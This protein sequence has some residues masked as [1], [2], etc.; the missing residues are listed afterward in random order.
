MKRFSKLLAVALAFCMVFS[1]NFIPASA[2]SATSIKLRI[3]GYTSN[4]TVVK[5]DKL[6]IFKL[7]QPLGSSTGGTICTSSNTNVVQIVPSQTSDAQYIKAVGAGTAVVTATAKNGSGAKGSITVRVASSASKA[8]SIDVVSLNANT[9]KGDTVIHKDQQLLLKVSTTPTAASK[10]MTYTSSNTNVATVSNTGRVTGHN[11]GT[12]TITVRTK[13]GSNKTA[14]VKVTVVASQGIKD[15]VMTAGEEAEVSDFIR[16]IPS[17]KAN[18]TTYTSDN[19]NVLKVVDGK[20]VA[21]SAGKAKV[22]VRHEA[23][24]LEKTYTFTVQPSEVDVE[25]ITASN[26]DDLHKDSSVKIDAKV[27]P[28]SA[29]QSLT[30]EVANSNIASVDSNGNVTGKSRGTTTIT[31]SSAKNPSI[32]KT[33]NVTVKEYLTRVTRWN[34]NDETMELVF[35]NFQWIPNNMEDFNEKLQNLVGEI[36]T[37]LGSNASSAKYEMVRNGVTYT[38]EVTSSGMV[39]KDADGN[40]VDIEAFLKN[41]QA[42]SAEIKIIVPESWIR[43]LLKYM[44]QGNTDQVLEYNGVAM[45]AA[46]FVGFNFEFGKTNKVTIVYTPTNQTETYTYF[47]SNGYL[48]LKSDTDGDVREDAIIKYRLANPG[49]PTYVFSQLDPGWY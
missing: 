13:D 28:A 47:V 16:I 26:I 43:T 6:A 19:E 49:G 10:M 33:I 41:G 24:E 27:L 42:S 4:I 40:Q 11:A 35:G 8:S 38:I 14:T 3:D 34:T 44:E 22:T 1:L 30:Y 36:H 31:I 12:A 32:T 21:V 7:A 18:F 37:K 25:S 2:A 17:S 45:S 48:Y 46:N 15:R 23:S 20:L 39:I 9:H 29:D 5:G